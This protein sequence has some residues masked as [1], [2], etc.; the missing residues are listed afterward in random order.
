[1]KIIAV[2]TET[3]LFTPFNKLVCFQWSDGETTEVLSGKF[4][5]ER[6]KRLL[7]S[8]MKDS[9][10]RLV[11]CNSKFD[12]SVLVQFFGSY[13]WAF[14]LLDAN[15]VIDLQLLEQL[16]L[17]QRG[18]FTDPEKKREKKAWSMAQ[19]CERYLGV[20]PDKGSDTWRLRYEEL[21]DVPVSEWPDEAY[22]YARK[23]AYLTQQLGEVM[24]KDVLPELTYGLEGLCFETRADFA[25]KVTTLTGIRTDKKK[26]NTLE[27]KLTS[28]I[29]VAFSTMAKAGMFQMNKHGGV[30]RNAKG[31]PQKNMAVIKGMIEEDYRSRGSIRPSTPTGEVAVS[32][33]ALRPCIA[34]PL[35]TFHSILKQ[36]KIL[37]TYIPFMK[38]ASVS[39]IYGEYFCL[40]STGRTASR[41]PNMQN[42][43]KDEV[44]RG[45]FI[46][47]TDDSVFISVDYDAAEL[48][49]HAQVCWEKYG[50]SDLRTAFLEGKD[51]HMIMAAAI[52]KK[53]YAWCVANKSTP[54][55]KNARALGKASNF[56]WWGGMG[57]P[58]FIADSWSKY[59]IR[60]DFATATMLRTLHMK[61][62]GEAKAYYADAAKAT[63]SLGDRRLTLLTGMTIGNIDYT[64][65]CNYQFQGLVGHGAKR[66]LYDVVKASYAKNGSLKGSRV[67][68]FIHDE[69]LLEVPRDKYH[70]YAETFAQIMRDALQKD[71]PDVPITASPSASMMLCKQDPK[72]NASGELMVYV[73]DGQWS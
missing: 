36:Y 8:W 40:V 31:N 39:N 10:V 51:P 73:G 2:D 22:A 25:L 38:E 14:K 47:S 44:V 18:E 1:M 49:A 9:E 45:C 29:D 4:D 13:D 61:M 37:N 26:V 52:L 11:F 19:L 23:D 54:E 27:H 5:R 64:Q 24:L 70:E 53:D 35:V 59:G 69:V 55:V 34:P 58:K 32:E 48:K 42:F 57:I 63:S 43:P 20:V 21:M 56:G 28:E 3:D 17:L 7:I 30:K 65:Y 33:E 66:A 67:A 68:Y 41:K 12:L 6:I 46:P 62:W 72:M 71:I 60:I 50:Y 16:I 15:Q